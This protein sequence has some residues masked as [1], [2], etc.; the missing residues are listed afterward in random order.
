MNDKLQ[1]YA[2]QCLKDGLA[3]LYE[4]HRSMFK[5]MY[6]RNG[7]KR[8]IEDALAMSIEDVV[9]EMSEDRLSLAM[10]Q[11]ERTMKKK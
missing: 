3:N 6:G 5:K 11:V 4:D 7:G 8:S 10:E 2:R 1:Q 9:D